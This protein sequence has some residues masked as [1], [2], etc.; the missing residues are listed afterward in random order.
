MCLPP[1][2][3]L[4]LTLGMGMGGG[5]FGTI[6]INLKNNLGPPMSKKYAFQPKSISLKWH[7][8]ASSPL[9][10]KQHTSP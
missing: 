3:R 9:F 2:R 7:I 8:L 5:A 1:S 4:L 6:L 10:E